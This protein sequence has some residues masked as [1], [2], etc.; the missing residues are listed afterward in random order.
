[1]PQLNPKE[2]EFKCLKEHVKKQNYHLPAQKA[3][4]RGVIWFEGFISGKSVLCQ[5]NSR[6]QKPASSTALQVLKSWWDEKLLTSPKRHCTVSA[7]QQPPEKLPI[8]RL[9]RVTLWITTLIYAQL[10]QAAT[11]L[12]VFQVTIYPGEQAVW[13]DCGNSFNTGVCQQG[14]WCFVYYSKN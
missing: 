10:T 12:L 1:M 2:Q 9:A 6:P 7:V 3:T 8:C 13:N 4:D 14:A 5:V 11:I